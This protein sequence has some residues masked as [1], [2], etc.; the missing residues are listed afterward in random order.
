MTFGVFMAFAGIFCLIMLLG[1][2]SVRR[3]ILLGIATVLMFLGM[4]YSGT[5][6][7]YAILPVGII[8]FI[9]MTINNY[10][11]LIFALLSFLT[12][13]FLIFGPIQNPI[14]NRFRSAFDE[15]D[16]SL[17]VRE[18]NRDYIQP[19][20][21]SHPMGGGLLTTG[22]TGL[23]YYPE[24]ELS[25]FATDSGFLKTALETGWIG[26]I[27]QIA[28]YFAALSY[29]LSG[30]YRCRDPQLRS[31]YAAYLCGF[32]AVT[33]ANFAQVASSKY[34]MGILIF[35]IYALFIQLNKITL[36]TQEKGPK[37]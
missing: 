4:A 32:F 17:Q 8:L 35:C 5:R 18:N 25:G 37:S 2:N 36:T 20:I 27:I 29:G 6:T 28:L 19:Y 24:H 11:T 34:P 23:K 22:D 7:A 10:K 30:F 21:W 15:D 12:F 33:I 14:L 26:L 31:L 3:R 1:P 13:A 16:P 9:V